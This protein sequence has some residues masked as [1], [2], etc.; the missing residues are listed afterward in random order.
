MNLTSYHTK[1]NIEILQMIREVME[2]DYSNDQQLNDAQDKIFNCIDAFS[3][4]PRGKC[5]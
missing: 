1:I 3:C 2:F 5:L 4:C